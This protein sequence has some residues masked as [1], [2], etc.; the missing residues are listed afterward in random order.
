MSWSVGTPVVLETTVR[1]SAVEVGH[2]G[3]GDSAECVQAD[4]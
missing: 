2:V 1:Q 3:A 4:P